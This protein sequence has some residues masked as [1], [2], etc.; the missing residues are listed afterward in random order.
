MFWVYTSRDIVSASRKGRIFRNKIAALN[1][2]IIWSFFAE[3]IFGGRPFPIFKPELSKLAVREREGYFAKKPSSDTL[4][5][6]TF[7]KVT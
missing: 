6:A 3:A 2:D 4:T 7:A 5:A 1:I